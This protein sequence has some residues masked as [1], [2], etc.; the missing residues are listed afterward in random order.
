M[1]KR[2][3]GT[4]RR[5]P[6]GRYQARVWMDGDQVPLGETFDT[7]KAAEAALARKQTELGRGLRIHPKAADQPLADYAETWLAERD[8]AERT[9]ELYRGLLDRHILPVFGT[10][11]IGKIPPSKVRAWNARSARQ[12]PSTAAKAY[13]LL[14][15]ILNTAVTDDLIDRS[16]CRVERAGVEHA[17]ERPTVTLAELDVIVEEMPER[18]KVLVLL[19]VWC[20][21]RRGELLGLRRRDVDLLHGTI[22][23]VQTIQR[24]GGRVV[25]K[26]PK[27]RAGRR[28]LTIPP[29]IVDAV[30][31]HLGVFVADDPDALVFTGVGGAPLAP[32]PFQK[33]WNRARAAAGRPDVH[34]HDLRHTGN[35]WAAATGA[36]TKELMARMGHDS[37][38]AAL[39]YQHATEDRDRVI[40]DALAA[41][42]A[43]APVVPISHRHAVGTNPTTAAASTETPPR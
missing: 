36:S 19:A 5:L 42:A 22:S 24:V 17:A 3:F 1:T 7:K 29:H 11:G 40:A 33:Y 15:T 41:F 20:Q 8:L 6:S 14:S 4:T 31:G 32:Q 13:R 43:P 35:T 2:S 27:S 21:L 38:R 28:R 30:A 34:L 39:I 23:V 18:F 26:E 37:P 9:R 16:P 25:V 12:H 10:D